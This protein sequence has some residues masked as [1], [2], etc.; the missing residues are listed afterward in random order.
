MEER[1]KKTDF[2]D[3][4]I[5]LSSVKF[6]RYSGKLLRFMGFCNDEVA[7][8]GCFLKDNG[9]KPKSVGGWI[10]NLTLPYKSLYYNA[11]FQCLTNSYKLHAE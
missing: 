3:P 1:K 4:L 6:R 10:G 5:L 8:A 11:S 2:I 7:H 9:V